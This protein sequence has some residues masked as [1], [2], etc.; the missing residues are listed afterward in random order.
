M[1]WREPLEQ[2]FFY[3]LAVPTFARLPFLF[4][5]HFPCTLSPKKTTARLGTVTAACDRKPRAPPAHRRARAISTPVLIAPLWGCSSLRGRGHDHPSRTL[6]PSPQNSVRHAL[7]TALA[8][9]NPKPGGSAGQ[10]G[11]AALR[12]APFPARGRGAAARTPPGRA[13]GPAPWGARLRAGRASAGAQGAAAPAGRP[14]GKSVFVALRASPPT[15]HT[16]SHT[17]TPL[18]FFFF[19]LF[20]ITSD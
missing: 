18:S 19:P 12:A 10:G 13:G 7:P 9:R 4:K 2:S 1:P 3:L 6:S 17:H 5:S 8:G 11:A 20:S 14:R 15:T 16:H